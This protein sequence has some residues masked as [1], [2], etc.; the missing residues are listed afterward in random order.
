[1]GQ[2][3]EVYEIVKMICEQFIRTYLLPTSLLSVL[4]LNTS[5]TSHL[6]LI[7]ATWRK[8]NTCDVILT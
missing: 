3:S 7:Y 2:V 6:S 5:Q 8:K 1:M 4:S